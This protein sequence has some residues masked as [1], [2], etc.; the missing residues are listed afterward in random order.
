MNALKKLALHRLILLH[1]L[2]IVAFAPSLDAQRQQDAARIIRQDPDLVRQRI[3]QSG[4]SPSEIRSRLGSAGLSPSLLD[5]FFEPAGDVP[6]EVSDDILSAVDLLGVGTQVVE[7]LEAVPVETGPEVS[8][9]PAPEEGLQLFGIDVFRRST[10]QF[11]PLL[12]GPVPDDYTIGPGDVMVL[13][14]TGDV[15]LSQA[16]EVTREGFIV[17]PSVGQIPVSNLTMGQLRVVLRQELAASYSGIDNGTTVFSV[18]ISQLRTNQIRVIGEVAQPSAYQ[19]VSVATVLNALYAAGGPTDNGNLRNVE[20]IRGGTVVGSFDLYDY[21][22]G[23]NT[24]NDITLTQGDVVFVPVK[25]KRVTLTGA[26]TREA[27]FEMAGDENLVDLINYAGGLTSSALVSRARIT[28]ILPAADRQVPGIDRTVFDIDLRAALEN[29][30]SA[31]MLLDADEVT[32]FRVRSEIRNTV[33]LSGSVWH[34][35]SFGYLNGM[36]AW[37]L[38]N[39]GDGL[40]PEAYLATA[41]IVRLNLADSTLSVIPFTLETLADGSPVEDPPLTEF[42]ALT[43]FSRVSFEPV[44]SIEVQGAVRNPGSLPRFEGMT[45]RDAI[46]RSGGLIPAQYSGRAFI[47][48]LQPDSTRRIVSLEMPVDSDMI[49]TVLEALEDYDIIRVPALSSFVDRF[50]VSISGEVRNATSLAFEEGMTLGDLIVLGGG[51][52]PM[53]DLQI[54]ISR[55]AEQPDRQAGTMARVMRLQVDS[56]FFLPQDQLRFYFGNADSLRG[57]DGESDRDFE[58]QPYDHVTVRRMP[59]FEIPGRVSLGGELFYPGTYVLERRD[60]RLFEVLARAGGLTSEAYPAGLK[61]TRNGSSV[62]IELDRVLR[63]S[64]HRDNIILLPG[65]DIFIPKYNPIV[66]VEGAVHT[67][68]SVLYREGESF[69]YYIANAGGYAEDAN[70]GRAFVRE[71]NGA[72]RTKSKFLFF[73]RAPEPGPGSTITVPAKL[74][75]EGTDLVALFSDITQIVVSGVTLWVVLARP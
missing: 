8:S 9:A 61:F 16:L 41:H 27:I 3:A 18:T 19:L 75:P 32:I 24:R 34:E 17:I 46:L 56:T 35:G 11:Q 71:A 2:A 59:D 37:D 44:H 10:A 66:V 49:P 70:A 65:D 69:D 14:L 21:I 51:L 55:L 1:A 38:I 53:A 54:A 5:S 67:P 64:G 29:P 33:S 58:L 20:V 60:Q 25:G 52:T 12:S 50:P 39:M 72:I 23:G 45:V 63:D 36:S 57:D 62:N 42:D 31:P 26:V 74:D 13:I 4:L 15:E 48:R 28:R 47:S 6:T 40:T 7:G 43:V 68:S 30:A 73:G 22:L